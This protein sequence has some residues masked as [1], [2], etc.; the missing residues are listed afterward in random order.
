MKE[1]RHKRANIVLSH[2]Y[3]VPRRGK[4]IDMRVEERLL[5]IWR[6]RVIDNLMG[7]QFLGNWDSLRW[8]M[9]ELEQWRGG[10]LTRGWL[11]RE[12]D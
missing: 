12:A 2:L 8:E 3:G 1:A 9:V 4:Y 10:G 5:G 7:T 6:R 11:T